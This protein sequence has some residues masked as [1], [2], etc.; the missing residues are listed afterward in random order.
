MFEHAGECRDDLVSIKDAEIK[1][2]QSRIKELE[3]V[4]TFRGKEHLCVNQPSCNHWDGECYFD[5]PCP[6]KHCKQARKENED[7]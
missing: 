5:G 6:Y 2:L 4:I 3:E 1:Q 7:V